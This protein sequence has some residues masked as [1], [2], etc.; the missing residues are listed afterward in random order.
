MISP[1]KDLE[2]ALLALPRSERARLAER[3]LASLD[4]DTEIQEAWEAEVK[5]RL[6]RYRAGELEAVTAESVHEEA[7]RRLSR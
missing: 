2:A 4:E 3:L 1:I 5:A 7:R 6:E